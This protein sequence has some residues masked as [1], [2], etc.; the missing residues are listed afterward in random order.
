[1]RYRKLNRTG[2][3]LSEVG[4][5]VWSVATKWWG[6][7]DESQGVKLLQKALDLGIN[8]YDTG[9]TY[10]NG[11]GETILAKAFKGRRHEIVIATKFGYDWYTYAGERTGHKEMPQDW[12]PEFIRKACEESLK[13]LNTDYIDLYQLHN[14][15][16]DAIGDDAIFD[17]LE[18]LKREGKVRY[19]GSSLGPDIGW[20]EEGQASMEERH[21][22]SLEI[23][24]SILEQE[25]SRRFFPIAEATDTGLLS[26]VP[27]ASGLLDG[28][29]D[30]S[31]VFP[32][33]DH[34]SHR[35]KE[36]LDTSLMK[37]KQ[38]GFLA[39]HYDMTI[40]Q[41]AVQ[42][43]LAEK[44]IVSVLP[45]LTNEPQLLEFAAASDLEAISAEDLAR[46]YDLFDN[47]FDLAPVSSSQA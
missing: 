15:R 41:A 25:P 29:V 38:L 19:W 36:W 13:R 40:G 17:T 6:V 7:E 23:I 8:F 4:F 39:E 35:K 42:F 27:H 44:N 31:T 16:I 24:H 46:L 34:R 14:P 21:A 45:N 47:D 9:D 37:V 1:M 32:E 3:N 5:G 22:D 12:S 30:E 2:L 28:T 10:G 18:Q 11:M 43:C 26:R 33:S 20:F